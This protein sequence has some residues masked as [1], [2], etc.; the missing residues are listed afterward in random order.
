MPV[1]STPDAFHFQTSSAL[2]I[3]AA[4]DGGLISSDGGA[5]LLGIPGHD[6]SEPVGP[7]PPQD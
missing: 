3:E 1:Q 5:L 4:F 2:P 6:G 7:G